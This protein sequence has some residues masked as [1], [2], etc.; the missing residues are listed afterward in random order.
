[1]VEK[2][3]K[4]CWRKLSMHWRPI[5]RSFQF[6]L[7]SVAAVSLVDAS[8]P[9]LNLIL[10]RGV[11]RGHEYTLKFSGERLADPQQVFLY[12]SGVEVI[13]IKSIDNR[14]VEV[15]IKVSP[16][17]R[18]GEHIAQ[19]RTK[20]GVSDFRS[21]YVGAL[22]DIAE[23][24]PNQSMR[25]AQPIA[26]NRTIN[27]VITN[28]DVD[29]YKI[30]AKQGERLSVEIEAIRLGDMFDPFIALLDQN[31]FEVAV[32]DDSSLGKQ[33]GIISTLIPEDGE[34]F[35]LVRE[36]AY[37]GNPRCRYRLHVGNFPRPTVAFPAGGPAE[38]QCDVTFLGDPTGDLK[39]KI[40]AH[41][42]TAFRDGIFVS[43]EFGI[44]PTPVEFRISNLENYLE[45]EPNDDRKLVKE[46][47]EVPCAFNGVIGQPRDTDYF[48]FSC[49]KGQVLD[50]ECFARRIGSGLDPIIFIFNEKGRRVANDDDSRRPD[51][52][53]R[54]T[55]PTDGHYF[56]SVKDHLQ[57]GQVD[58]AYRIEVDAVRP[59]LKISIPRVDR[60]SQ[61]RQQICIPRGN[62]FA[63][64]ISADRQ[65]FSGPLELLPIDL[66]D[67]VSV[68]ARTM[69]G[70]LNLMPVVFS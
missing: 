56:V 15:T 60:F 7:L 61:L 53:L 45:N 8:T 19:L 26:F 58:F 9:R 42:Q 64:L 11:Q 67:H 2:F 32:S 4:N 18:L 51:S 63:T 70:N 49:K 6:C 57:R 14:N 36:A 68:D 3:A 1:M 31:R 65:N 69:A 21:F 12:D 39:N 37:G 10:P 43:D 35:I 59:K 29:V 28:E 34:Y 40:Q 38:T 20:R 5:K 24:E 66:P 13:D 23:L 55:A 62:R 17:C 46:P 33:D 44:V 48:K 47:F 50:V 27:G 25:E 54:F 22:Q 16:E 41:P 30:N 52:Y